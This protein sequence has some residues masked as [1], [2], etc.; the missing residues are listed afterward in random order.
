MLGFIIGSVTGS[1]LGVTMM[2]LCQAAGDADRHLGL[3]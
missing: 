2:C 3:K 1:V